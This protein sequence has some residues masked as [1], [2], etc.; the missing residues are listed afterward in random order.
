MP[1]YD[2]DAHVDEPTEVFD[3]RYLDPAFRSRRPEAV[4]YGGRPHW[5][6]DYQVFP[7]FSGPGPHS[8]G[9][10]THVGQVRSVYAAVKPE[11]IESQEL[12]DPR[13]RLR[14]M[15]EEGIDLQVLYPSLFLAYNLSPDPAYS[16]ALCAAYNRW[17]AEKTSGFAHRLRWAAV[18]NLEDVRLAVQEVRRARELGAVG[19]MVPGTA[20]DRL[21][22]HPSLLPFFEEAAA[23]QLPIAVHVAW[24]SPSLDRLAGELYTS[25]LIPFTFSMLCGFIAVLGSGLLDRFPSLRFAFL[26]GGCQWVHFLQDRMD[27][28]FDFT[29]KMRDRGLPISVPAA[30]ER[31]RDYLRRGNVYFSFE[32]EDALLPQVIELVGPGQLLWASDMPHADR[33]RYAART[34][35]ERRDI[36]Q[37]DV[38]R[39]LYDNPKRFYGL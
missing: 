21:L 5:L 27:H 36:S 11:S 13:A 15:D 38:D 29:H 26:E 28:R 7:R 14:D 20:G 2:A 4:V 18:V 23:Q 19:L 8:M 17:L 24:S 39:I 35:R 16:A 32:V 30:R 9:T 6:I 12:T 10:P 3:D 25:T 34:L 1:V 31:V 33:E 22:D 37:A